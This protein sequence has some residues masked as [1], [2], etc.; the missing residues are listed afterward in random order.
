MSGCTS[1]V[2]RP[3]RV[4]APNRFGAARVSKRFDRPTSA[5]L[6]L[7]RMPRA[8]ERDG[9]QPV[10]PCGAMRAA[11]AQPTVIRFLRDFF[12]MQRGVEGRPLPGGVHFLR[13]FHDL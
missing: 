9:G 10:F 8:D 3:L 12:V 13:L 5:K 1:S 4:A 6:V 7:A 2:V 11:P